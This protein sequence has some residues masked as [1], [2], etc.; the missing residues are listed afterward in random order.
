MSEG[1]RLS[2][3]EF[4]G[5]LCPV[6]T[7]RSSLL[8]NMAA[9]ATAARPAAARPAA[10]VAAAAAS[11]AASAAL[12]F[13]P[14]LPAALGCCCRAGR[15]TLLLRGWARAAAGRGSAQAM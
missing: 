10:G 12:M 8:R 5:V 3:A 14:R 13:M 11:G 15:A 2:T 9:A 6:T 7:G 4:Q 1:H